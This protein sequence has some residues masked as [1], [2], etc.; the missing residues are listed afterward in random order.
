MNLLS[1]IVIFL[2][3]VICG[4]IAFIA[5]ELTDDG[6]EHRGKP[7]ASEHPPEENVR[8]QDGS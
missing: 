4:A 8:K 2:A 5:W 6:G 1:L 7:P 3:V